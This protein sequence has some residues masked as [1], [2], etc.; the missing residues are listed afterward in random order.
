[1]FTI[2]D[3]ISDNSIQIKIKFTFTVYEYITAYEYILLSNLIYIYIYIYITY[4]I[5]IR[6]SFDLSCTD[7]LPKSET[8]AVYK[9]IVYVYTYTYTFVFFVYCNIAATHTHAVHTDFTFTKSFPA[10]FTWSLTLVET[11]YPNLNIIQVIN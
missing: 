3:H 5:Y 8:A 2:N 1:M 7:E 4:I 6:S 10:G 9:L 11:A